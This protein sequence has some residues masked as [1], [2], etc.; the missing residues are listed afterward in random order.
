MLDLVIKL[1]LVLGSFFYMIFNLLMYLFAGYVFC[2]R[3]K[4]KL[5]YSEMNLTVLDLIVI[6][7][8]PVILTIFPYFVFHEINSN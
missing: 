4:I 2:N 8:I 6:C 3:K 5:G 7:L 1:I